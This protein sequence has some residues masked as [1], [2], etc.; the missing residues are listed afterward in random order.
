MLEAVQ[1][2]LDEPLR[3]AHSPHQNK[4]VGKGGGERGGRAP[5][6]GGLPGADRRAA[7]GSGFGCSLADPGRRGLAPQEATSSSIWLIAALAPSTTP[8]S[9]TFCSPSAVS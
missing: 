5:T 3:C 9:S 8:I 2:A 1:D 7:T 6:S 4:E